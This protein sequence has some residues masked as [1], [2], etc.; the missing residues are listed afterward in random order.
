MPEGGAKCLGSARCLEESS[1]L[2]FGGLS[3]FFGDVCD[4]MHIVSP[5]SG[6]RP[7]AHV[8]RTM[9]SGRGSASDIVVL[10]AADSELSMLSVAFG[11][12]RGEWSARKETPSFLRLISL[13]ELSDEHAVDVFLKEALSVWGLRVVLR[14]AVR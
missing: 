10:S 2:D 4:I 9:Q 5:S 6:A 11:D 8:H 1:A 12:L 3:S 13:L 14:K 7:C